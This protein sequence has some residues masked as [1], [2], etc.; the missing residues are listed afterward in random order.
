MAC[1]IR[2][3]L[4]AQPLALVLTLREGLTLAVLVSGDCLPGNHFPHCTR[5][6]PQVSG[7]FEH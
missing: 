4:A 2:L 5:V 1:S 7:F 3:P 6:L